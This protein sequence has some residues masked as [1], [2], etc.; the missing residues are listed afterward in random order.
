M[1][2]SVTVVSAMHQ[3]KS[4]I[5]IYIYI[6]IYVYPLPV[7]PPSSRHPNSLGHHR[8][9]GWA[10]CAIQQL[11]LVIYFTCDSVCKSMLRK[12]CHWGK[13]RGFTLRHKRAEM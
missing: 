7:E 2:Y 8:V 11:M 3:C 6:Y 5:I 12:E 4:V 13:K 10:S 9:R 1:L